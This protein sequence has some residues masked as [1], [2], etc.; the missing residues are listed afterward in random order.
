M[1]IYKYKCQDCDQVISILHSIDDVKKDCTLC[2]ATDSLVKMIGKPFI[3]KT[4]NITDAG[5]GALTKKFI[6]DNKEVL[7]KQKE[8]FKNKTYDES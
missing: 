4:E 2:D 8:E 5:T 6:E 1:P 3:N 7:Q